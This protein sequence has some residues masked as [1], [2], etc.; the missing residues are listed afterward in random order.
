MAYNIGLDF[1]TTYSV[2]SRMKDQFDA[3]GNLLYAEPEACAL[4][5]NS[6]HCVDSLVL[7][8]EDGTLMFGEG[9]RDNTGLEGAT[10]YKGFKMLLAETD[11]TKLSQRGYDSEFTPRRITAEYLEHL[12]KAHL[13][14]E[15]QNQIDNLV[16]GIPQVWF[17]GYSTLSSQIVLQEILSRFPF[18]KNVE[19]VSEP[20]AAC[21]YFVNNFKKL[22]NGRLFD[23][24]ILLVDYGGGTLDIAL[25]DVKQTETGNEVSVK[26]QSGAGKNQDAFIGKAGMA[27]IEAVILLALEPTGMSKEELIANPDFYPCVHSLEKELIRKTVSIQERFSGSLA[28]DRVENESKFSAISFDRKRYTITYGMLAQAFEALI[29]PVLTEELNSIIAYMEKEKIDWMSDRFKIALVGGFCNFFLTQEFVE[30]KF[31]KSEL[32]DP[33]F[34]GIIINRRDCEKAISFGAALIANEVT[35]FKQLSPYHL[36]FAFGNNSYF[37]FHKGDE[38]EYNVPHFVK[39]TAG[40]E[41]LFLVDKISRLVISLEDDM[42]DLSFGDVQEQYCDKLNF[43]KNTYY[44]IGFSVDRAMRITIHK[45]VVE[46]RQKKDVIIEKTSAQLNGDFYAVIGGG[47][48]VGG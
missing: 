17:G 1:G 23:G 44:K 38:L 27:Y 19:P 5:E 36:G 21:A 30:E 6:S 14:N 29:A 37:A 46:S 28:E 10:T 7:R 25:C 13:Y 34:D 4:G 35:S 45:H 12:L 48:H 39:N 2:I 18:V 33:R 8:D 24:Q 16:V 43:K 47:A 26:R 41:V 40:E 11:E 31:K 15:K 22:N 42:T 20:A 32:G 9:A 3:S